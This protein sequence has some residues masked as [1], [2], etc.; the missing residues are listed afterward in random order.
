[1]FENLRRKIRD[2][3]QGGSMELE[4]TG[5]P[6]QFQI[7]DRLAVDI[8]ALVAPDGA[9]TNPDG[10]W[11]KVGDEYTRTLYIHTYPSQVEDNWL[12]DILRFQETMDAAIYI[13][14]IPIKAY[15]KKLRQQVARDEA[16]IR[17]EEEDGLIPRGDKI[18]RYRDTLAYITAIEQ[19]QTKPFQIMVAMTLRARTVEDLDR[20]QNNLEERLNSI[21]VNQTRFMHKE[22]FEST[23]PLMSNELA[24][25]NTVRPI[26]TQGL[27]AAFPFTSSDITHPSGVLIGL[28]QSTSSPII[29]NRFLQAEGILENPNSCILGATGSGKSYFAKL[30]MLRSNYQ[31]VPVI[32]LD[33][34]GEYSRVCRRVGGS[35]IIISLDSH[36]HI[37]P[38]DFSYAVAPGK[39]ALREKVAYMVELLRVMIRSGDDG[40][41]VP[42][43]GITREIFENALQNVYSAYGY[44]I[45]D[46]ATQLNADSEQM[47]TMTEVYVM[48]A[49]LAK[50]TSDAMRRERL[51]LLL[52]ALG[53]FVGEGSLAKLFDN[54]TTVDLR[55]HFINFNYAALPQEMLP[56]AMHLVLEFLRTSLFTEAQAESGINRLLYIDEAQKLMSFPETAKFVDQVF[57]TCRKYGVGATVMTQNVGTF[58]INDD[59]SEN[60]IGQAILGQCAVK[61][62]LKQEPSEAE[63]IQRVFKLTQSELSRLLGA[64]R[65]QGLI[66]VGREVGWFTA[67]GL[68]SEL[69]NEICTTT[70]AERAAIAAL[71]AGE[72]GDE[73]GGLLGMYDETR[74]LLAG[75]DGY[76]YNAGALPAAG[77]S[78]FEL[79]DEDPFSDTPFAD[80]PSDDD[81][82]SFESL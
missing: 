65:G 15:V 8:P 63:N 54:R 7:F 78:H 10:T 39:N 61:I 11:F 49:R 38:L 59:G 30:E 41:G 71:Q 64:K 18:M 77:D 72:D 23:L 42:I 44:D 9:Q 34:S 37:N 73:S 33:P 24:D 51:R 27:M 75:D 56:L 20:I 45:E 21:T 4:E 43:D 48:L 31:G 16:A 25:M 60:K 19:Q 82:G 13:Q 46:P 14:P 69:E 66:F 47:P 53:R 32:T 40:G 1:M 50:G 67:T 55:S 35:D 12:R 22:G 80:D 81:N 62:L 58:V 26:H 79:D 70:P 29:V 5:E 68:A 57:R 52:P 2:A 17:K 74:E 3:Q 76:G 36:D 6:K 28:S